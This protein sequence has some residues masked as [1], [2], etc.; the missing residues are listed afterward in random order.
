MSEKTELSN[1]TV[2]RLIAQANKF[3]RAAGT[4]PQI[5][6][7]LTE[8]GYTNEDHEEGW[9]YYHILCGY[10]PSITKI[11]SEM[12]IPQRA[13]IVELDQWDEPAFA[14]AHAALVRHFPEQD[15]YL[16]TGL[17][18]AQGIEAVATVKTFLDR[19]ETL[20]QGSDPLRADSRKAD[21]QAVALLEKRNIIN[22]AMEKHLRALIEVAVQLAPLPTIPEMLQEMEEARRQA[23]LELKDWLA[24]WRET[25]RAGIKRRDY[26]ISLG[27]SKRRTS[28]KD[29]DDDSDDNDDKNDNADKKNNALD[30]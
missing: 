29:E 17:S 12:P 4:K 26:Q 20:R 27:L 16:F 5:R 7:A 25:A 24:E 9:S 30:Y 15:V 8:L 10:N 1:A 14:R 11:V 6:A 28:K 3:L 18:A 2:E 22:K 19:V 23:S 13:A 21:K